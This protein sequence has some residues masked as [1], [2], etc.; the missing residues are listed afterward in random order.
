[1]VGVLVG[2]LGLRRLKWPVRRGS[3]ERSTRIMAMRTY[4]SVTRA[5]V[6]IIRK[7]VRGTLT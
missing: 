3:V 5:T 1:M 6:K 2:R 4:I 7:A